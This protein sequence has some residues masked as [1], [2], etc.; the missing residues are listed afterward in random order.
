MAFLLQPKVRPL[1]LGPALA[2]FGLLACFDLILIG[3][4]IAEWTM[5]QGPAFEVRWLLRLEHLIAVTEVC[6]GVDLLG[7]VVG[8]LQ[9]RE[10]GQ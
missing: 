10:R 9:W 8:M 1:E 2:T 3:V 5:S 7:F 6:S 4:W